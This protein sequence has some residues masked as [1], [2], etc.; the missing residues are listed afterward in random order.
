MRE[1][2]VHLAE[3]A[4]LP[5]VLHIAVFDDLSHVL[6]LRAGLPFFLLS[7]NAQ[8]AHDHALLASRLA[9][10]EKKA[11]IHAF[12]TCESENVVDDVAQEKILPFLRAEKAKNPSEN[13]Q[14]GLQN[15]QV[16]SSSSSAHD[17][18]IAYSSAAL[19]TTSVI[20]RPI[21]PFVTHGDT[22][23]QVAIVC[24]GKLKF[25]SNVKG[26]FLVTLSLLNPPSSSQI[27]DSLPPSV[28][29]LIVLEQVHR[30]NMKMT[31][32]FLDIVGTLQLRSQEQ[33]PL[34][35]SGT[36]GETAGLTAADL[37]DFVQSAASSTSQLQLGSPPVPDAHPTEPLHIPKHEFVYTRILTQL[38]GDR[39]EV[40][41][42]PILVSTHGQLA[43]SP[44]F[45]LGRVRAQLE[46]RMLLVQLVQEVLESGT[47]SVELH[48][49]LSQWVS[50][51][52]DTSKSRSLGADIIKSLETNLL[53]HPAATQIL[54]LKDHFPARS[55][56]IIGSDAWSYDLGASGLHHTIASGL[57]IN[58]LIL[59]TL[60]Y[61]LRGS[62]DPPRRKR[63]VGLYA[64]NHGDVYVASVAIYSS[65][66]HVLQSLVEADRFTGP[67]VVLAY[68]PYKDEQTHTL[69]IL[70]ET[71]LAVDAGYWPL[72]RWDPSRERLGKEPFLLDSD[73]VKND[74]REFLDRQNHIS[75][76][77]LS[78]PQFAAELVSGLGDNVKEARKR[79]A[80]ELYDAL[81]T[82]INA[83][84]LTVLYA[85]DGGKAEKFAKR[86]A[87]RGKLR[88]LSATVATMDSMPLENLAA[89]EHVV[90]VTSTAGQGE[91]P[92]NGR[93]FFKALNAAAAHGDR[94]FTKLQFTVF[95][96]G[97]SH[98]WP[99]PEDAQYYNK[100]GK[101]LNAR[102]EQLGGERIADLGL[103]DDQ[104]AD[105]PET[106]YKLW[107]PT[108]WKSLGVDAVEV[109]EAEPE[110]ITNEHI[111]AASRYLRGTIAEGLQDTTTGS[112]APSDG[113]I[114]KFHGIYQQDDRDIRDERQ[115]QG[116]E[117]AYSFMIRVRMPGGVCTPSQWLQIDQ[118]ADEHGSGTFK[119][120]TRQTFQ[121]HGVIKKHLKP[122]IQAINKALLD[123]IA[124]CGDVN[125]YITFLV[126][127]LLV[128]SCF[129]RNV[130]C[131]A[132][133]A[134]SK[135]HTQVYEFSKRVSERLLPRTTA[136]HEIWL[137][138][139]LVAGEAVKDFEPLYGEVYL[140]RKVYSNFPYHKFI[141]TDSNSS[142]LPSL[143]PQRTMSTS[144]PTTLV[145]SPL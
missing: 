31:P 47:A 45:A 121:F 19:M 33:R 120:T 95:G 90:F 105:G 52:D 18:F 69:D 126:D 85:S 3:L 119:I 117:P 62:A 122:S 49:L 17:R 76:L 93:S 29:R 1:M 22:D 9:R 87:N 42:S 59:D 91:P 25:P 84:P 58:L 71:K 15:G 56:W 113:Q 13:L 6:L 50:S 57:N 109:I 68:L 103:G 70:K 73:A 108:L 40:S 79:K 48:A 134:F 129:Y 82:S 38:F 111:K 145:S 137:D 110:P 114:T 116:L 4:D 131:S 118:I 32:L 55:R 63:D 26:I 41:N 83:P 39:L 107:E 21:Q 72:Y 135:L 12:Y 86:L 98:Y 102:L 132:I 66:S 104:D 106:G 2:L 14:N 35:Q 94:P 141:E 80:Q 27:L 5:V 78:K 127:I 46:Q 54:S 96:L 10:T 100:P 115:A 140:P 97:D 138:K 44:E 128:L 144:S 101:D 142:K 88:G 37:F 77:V 61:S 124:A 28:S 65:Y 7:Y 43:T 24:L 36:L 139:K 89:E 133:P 11:V 136:Y 75:Q 30:W 123:T 130:I 16:V 125:R 74:L 64:M 92:Q 60:P 112:L 81:L 99:R 51:R 20:R 23:S 143:F 34:V 53:P 67:S 8:Q